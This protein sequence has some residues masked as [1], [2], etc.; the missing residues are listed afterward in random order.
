MTILRH[1]HRDDEALIPCASP[2]PTPAAYLSRRRDRDRVVGFADV[3]EVPDPDWADAAP[4]RYEVAG[5]VPPGQLVAVPLSADP[6]P[7][8]LA[9]WER[10]LLALPEGE[11]DPAMERVFTDM[12]AQADA[13]DAW[14]AEAED[15]CA[16]R[17]VAFEAVLTDV[18]VAS[19][20]RCEAIA[21]AVR[22]DDLIGAE[23]AAGT[24]AVLDAVAARP[25]LRHTHALLMS[26][27][28]IVARLK[29][30]EL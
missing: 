4:G 12:D 10:E 14:Y 7:E 18:R 11:P 8:P 13:V 24:A 6:E 9:D 25:E 27:A 5:L 3:A 19:A 22:T 28:P 23:L 30:V 2:R 17:D 1:R 15:V 21:A 16:S 20:E 29:G 26:L